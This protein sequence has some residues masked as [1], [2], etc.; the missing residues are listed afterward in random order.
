MPSIDMHFK[1]PGTLPS[2]LSLVL[3]PPL[4]SASDV[5]SNFPR[6]LKESEVLLIFLELRLQKYLVCIYFLFSFPYN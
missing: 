4:L 1:L 6:K 3:F 2:Q 5:V